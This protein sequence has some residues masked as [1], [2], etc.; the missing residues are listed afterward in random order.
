MQKKT[1][2]QELHPPAPPSSSS[3]VT[4]TPSDSSSCIGYD[5]SEKLITITCGS[6]T[7]SELDKQLNDGNVPCKENKNDDTAN[8]NDDDNHNAKVWLLNAGLLI[9][10]GAAL[11]INSTDTKWLKIIADG[12]TAYGIHVLGTL[13]IDSVKITSWDPSTNDYLKFKFEILSDRQFEESGIDA[14]PRPYI[15]TEQGETGTTDITNSELAYLGYACGGGC[16]GLSYYAGEGSVVEGNNI[17]NNR[18]GFYSNGASKLI[19]QHNNVHHNFM[20]GF[21]PHTGTH[22]VIIRNNIVHDNGAMGIICSLNC[23]NVTIE[24]N[25]VYNSQGSG[26]MFSRN[27]T[28]SVVRN[29]IVHNEDNCILVSQSHSVKSTVIGLQA[30]R[31][32]SSCF[33]IRLTIW[34]MTTSSQIL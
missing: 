19:L 20:Y 17:H 13:K 5:S 12:T 28:D 4:L 34:C 32:L 2:K 15:I 3:S 24:N 25:E 27:M 14:I 29:N 22:D 23:Y 33:I 6:T 11:Y 30:A 9:D 21:D 1:S 16:S 7:L 31:L 10:K 26:I 8:N 18:F